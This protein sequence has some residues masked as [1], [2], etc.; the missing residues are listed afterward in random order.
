MVNRIVRR[1]GQSAELTSQLQFRQM[2]RAEPGAD[3][4]CH[5]LTVQTERRGPHQGDANYYAENYV[6]NAGAHLTAVPR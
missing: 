2:G 1:G 5:E 3:T 4:N 6:A